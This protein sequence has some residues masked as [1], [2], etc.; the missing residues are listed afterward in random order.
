M[1]PALTV[2]AGLVRLALA[3]TVKVMAKANRVSCSDVAI[4]I[5]VR[6]PMGVAS[7]RSQ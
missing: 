1:K 5:T 4:S 2:M 3:M 6:T 7:L